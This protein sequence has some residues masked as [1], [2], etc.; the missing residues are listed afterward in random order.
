M[1]IEQK[2]IDKIKIAFSKMQ[3]KGD[4][5]NLLNEAKPFVY[6]E[7]AVPFELK[8]LTWY[9]NPKLSGKRYTEFKI[10]KKSG[11]DRLIHAP[12]RGL[13]AIQKTFSFILQCVFEPHKAATGFVR[14]K[15]IVDNARVHA[16]SNYVY[17][18]DLKDFFSSIDQARVWKCLQLPPFN[19]KKPQEIASQLPLTKFSKDEIIEFINKSNSK[20]S[21]KKADRKRIAEST[22]QDEFDKVVQRL[23][24]YRIAPYEEQDWQEPIEIISLNELL[25]NSTK[26]SRFEL[27]NMISSIC[28]TEME[29]E[30][31]NEAGEWK[32]VKRNVLPQ[33]APTSPVI[34]NVVCQRIDFLL[35]GVAKRFRL[36]YSRYA[37][38]ITFSSMH[39]V[40]QQ[41]SDFIKELHRI[42][43]EQ[44]FHI[45]E[46]KTRLQ[47]Q[48]FRQ[49]VTGLL[50]NEKA[51]VQQ[52]YI[53]QLRMWLHYWERYGYERAY[54]F[55]LKQY[56]ADKGHVIKGK[57]DMANV[58]KGKLDFLKMVKGEENDL[59]LKLKSR[60]DALVGRT[61][62]LNSIID[63]WEKDG[64]EKAMEIFY[65]SNTSGKN[66][67]I[68]DLNDA[69]MVVNTMF[70]TKP[71]I[72]LKAEEKKILLSDNQFTWLNV[73]F[74]MQGDRM[75]SKEDFNELTEVQKKKLIDD[76]NKYTGDS[77]LNIV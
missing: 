32:L 42:I 44:G 76:Y 25:G 20:E 26:R 9:A 46:S 77:L 57:P 62:P 29:V 66:R 19:L 7:K 58:I 17:N 52:R 73:I 75:Y 38:D 24:S 49:E 27:N 22:T 28:C 74:T 68:K 18:I 10:K 8:Q 59:Y 41:E 31:K 47:K 53:K 60:L 72:K 50:V 64:I 43:A 69:D 3:S 61:D 71:S 1:K 6:G 40:Y 5:L 37:D 51:N 15:S 55:F 65:S 34:T 23:K 11:S 30:R 70:K 33:G 45:K 56:L 12:V 16:G 21:Y 67:S 13:K 48:G 63:I 54:S 35:S 39:N 4:L 36:K 14:D 2:H